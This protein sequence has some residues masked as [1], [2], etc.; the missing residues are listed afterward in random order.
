MALLGLLKKKQTYVISLAGW[1]IILLIICGALI[2]FALNVYSY[3][4]VTEPV[5]SNILVVEGWLPDY[6]LESAANEFKNG[7]YQLLVTTG[8]PLTKGYL[9]SKYKT[10]A[11]LGAEILAKFGVPKKKI[12]VVPSPNTDKDR[13]Q[14]SAIALN[15]WITDTKQQFRSINLLTLGVHA[16]RSRNLYMETLGKDFHIGIISVADQSYY[17]GKWW[18]TSR[19]FKVVMGEVVSYMYSLIF[20]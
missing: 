19:G 6:A 14:A 10:E 18:S 15:Y 11:E 12:A 16:R 9:L 1:L 7:N 2:F 5:P 3:L 8:A 17:P 4:A 20:N 13:T